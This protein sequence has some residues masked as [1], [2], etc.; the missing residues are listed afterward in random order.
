MGNGGGEELDIQIVGLVR[1]AKYSEV[2]GVIPAQF[3]MPY[4]QDDAIGAIY[5]YVR[6]EIAAEQSL[7]M[8]QAV[9]RSLDENLPVEDLKT[10][11]QQIRE[12]VVV[13]RLIGTLSA[14]FAGLATLLAAI[15]LYGVVAYTVTQRTREFGLR[16]ALGADQ[17]KVR[18]MVL[19][20]VSRM[21]L[22]G[23]AIGLVAAIG[24]GRL[25]GSMLYE[26]EPHD[27]SVL[28]L[29]VLLLAVVALGAGFI[30]ARKASRID[31]MQALR[32]E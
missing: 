26:I 22:V 6:S 5:F 11:H 9:V 4:R 25:A 19:E 3:F 10:M 32:Y 23:G 13:D 24:L 1:D 2:K 28:I 12:N 18:G 21:T 20:K 15:G 17:A 16:M 27:P 30:P 29:S 7:S 31:P 8:I 14:A